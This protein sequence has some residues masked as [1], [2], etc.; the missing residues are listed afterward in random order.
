MRVARIGTL[1]EERP[2]CTLLLT[3]ANAATGPRSMPAR[4]IY[5]D[6][7][8][9]SASDAIESWATITVGCGGSPNSSIAQPTRKDAVKRLRLTWTFDED[10]DG[11]TDVQGAAT[12]RRSRLVHDRRVLPAVSAQPR[13]GSSY[14]APSDPDAALGNAAA[15]V[16]LCRCQSRRTD[17]A[18]RDHLVDWHST[19]INCDPNGLCRRNS[20]LA[21]NDIAV[22]VLTA[23]FTEVLCAQPA[24]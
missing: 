1:F 13:R 7:V 23:S 2:G 12:P 14:R 24:V 6:E 18:L 4:C 11:L 8:E 16:Q 21:V 9:P 10:A 22:E 3:G 5:V 17:Q 15:V 19:L 20:D